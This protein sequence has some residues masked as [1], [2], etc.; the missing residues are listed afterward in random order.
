MN[1]QSPIRM[2]VAHGHA[3][4]GEK[5]KENNN[6]QDTQSLRALAH[7]F[8]KE[9]ASTLCNPLSFN[10]AN[11]APELLLVLGGAPSSHCVR[12]SSSEKSCR[13]RFF[14]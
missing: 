4:R 5:E 14:V 11:F 13:S 9:L 7:R 12:E 8:A 3:W 6:K 2:H 10:L 1:A